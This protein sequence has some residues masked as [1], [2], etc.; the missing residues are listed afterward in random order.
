MRF[1]GR[2][3]AQGDLGA[4]PRRF[5]HTWRGRRF[6]ISPE[7]AANI[8]TRLRGRYEI[9]FEWLGRF[10]KEAMGRATR[11][12]VASG[13]TLR[14]CEAP[15]S[16]RRIRQRGLPSDGC[17]IMHRSPA[18]GGFTEGCKKEPFDWLS[19]PVERLYST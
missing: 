2:E 19:Q 17:C 11:N 15:T 14:G 7:K 18:H 4:S 9:A 16:T 13:N 12:I 3:A 6:L 10:C 5:D 8:R 1:P